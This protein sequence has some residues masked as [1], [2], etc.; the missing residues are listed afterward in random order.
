MQSTDRLPG[1]LGGFEGSAASL[2][3]IGG[4]IGLA[5]EDSVWKMGTLG[6]GDTVCEREQQWTARASV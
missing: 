3:A 6:H 2:L 1:A 5:S 4:A